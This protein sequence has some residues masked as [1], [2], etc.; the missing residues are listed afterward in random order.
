[1]NLNGTVGD[2]TSN[3]R[4]NNRELNAVEFGTL[5]KVLGD[6]FATKTGTVKKDGARGKPATI[7]TISPTSPVLVTEAVAADTVADASAAE[8][9]SDA[10]AEAETDGGENVTSDEGDVANPDDVVL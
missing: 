3:L 9:T 5:I 8:D 1:M 6:S 4:F 2:L 7:W 10:T